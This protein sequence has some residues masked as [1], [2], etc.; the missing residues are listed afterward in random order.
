MEQPTSSGVG[1][2]RKGRALTGADIPKS[3]EPI[4]GL[5][6]SIWSNGVGDNWLE[7][8][9]HA[10][11]QV[12]MVLPLMDK[13]GEKPQRVLEIG[14]ASGWRLKALEEKYGCEAWGVDPSDDSI[15]AAKEKGCKAE[16]ATSDKLPFP[17]SGFDY[18]IFGFCLCFISPEDWPALVAES[19]RVLCQGGHLII[20]DFATSG[21][22]KGVLQWVTPSDDPD[23]LVP[24]HIFYYPWK[25][26]WLSHPTYTQ[27]HEVFNM[28][29]CE[30]AVSLRK[31]LGSLIRGD[32]K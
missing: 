19:D 25:S 15:K 4:S 1:N 27:T 16:R 13:I 18:V 21:Y 14:C 32:V 3:Y 24:N 12:D 17:D 8:N 2:A 26:L 28:Q 29:K 23:K 10:L 9:K 11:G 22:S 7:R 20:N 30:M 31:D 6:R 5:Q